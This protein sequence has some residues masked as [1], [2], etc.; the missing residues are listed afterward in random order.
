MWKLEG[1]VGILNKI[2]RNVFLCTN[3]IEINLEVRGSSGDLKHF[4]NKVRITLKL[5]YV[6]EIRH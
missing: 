2:N 4:N 5:R 6:S 3:L 1:K